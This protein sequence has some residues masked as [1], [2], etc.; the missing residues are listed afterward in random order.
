MDRCAAP[1]H[2]CDFLY[3]CCASGISIA[4]SLLTLAV[5]F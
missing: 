5:L 3:L 2:Q 4:V 1:I